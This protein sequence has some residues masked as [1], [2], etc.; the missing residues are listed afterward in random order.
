M[1]PI[2]E[3]KAIRHQLGATAGYDVHRVFGELQELRSKSRRRYLEPP[4]EE[5]VSGHNAKQAD[6]EV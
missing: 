3:I 5:L 4:H 6:K 2:E 1:N